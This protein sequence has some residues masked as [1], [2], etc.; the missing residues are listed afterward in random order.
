MYVS[1]C[2]ISRWVRKLTYQLDHVVQIVPLGLLDLSA[3]W[4]HVDL[5]HLLDQT[6]P[7]DH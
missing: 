1:T 6:G 7:Q 5:S 4:G 2:S 3:P